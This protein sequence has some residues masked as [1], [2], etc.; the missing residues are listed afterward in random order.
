MANPKISA[1]DILKKVLL[2]LMY[3]AYCMKI[4]LAW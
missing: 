1:K 2:P 3:V 4:K